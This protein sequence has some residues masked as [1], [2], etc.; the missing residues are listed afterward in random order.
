MY[1]ALLIMLFLYLHPLVQVVERL[2]V[3][4]QIQL[5]QLLLMNLFGLLE[6]LVQEEEALEGQAVL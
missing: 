3:V 6:E 4:V 5:E 1:M 2:V